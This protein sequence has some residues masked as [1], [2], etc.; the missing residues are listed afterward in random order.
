M[1]EEDWA[2]YFS[3]F[4]IFGY[5]NGKN[6]P[7]DLSSFLEGSN[8]YDSS[9]NFVSFLYEDLIIDNNI[10]DISLMIQ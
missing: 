3:L 2:D 1:E 6:S 8:N 4:M 9:I 5:P 10:F 7:K